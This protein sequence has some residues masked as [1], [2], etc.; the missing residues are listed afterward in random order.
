M[1]LAVV[2]VAMLA[3]SGCL[4][5]VSKTETLEVAAEELEIASKSL[6]LA[7][8]NGSS[9][10]TTT[11]TIPSATWTTSPF[12]STNYKSVTLGAELHGVPKKKAAT[13]AF[14]EITEEGTLELRALSMA[15]GHADMAY[16]RLIDR[17]PRDL[18][19]LGVVGVDDPSAKVTLRIG[20]VKDWWAPLPIEN[21]EVAPETVGGP[22]SVGFDIDGSFISPYGGTYDY[23]MRYGVE[24]SDSRVQAV[25]ASAG[26]VS[27][28][29]KHALSSP[30]VS[31][32]FAFHDSSGG[33]GKWTAERNVDGE[34]KSAEGRF[35][36]FVSPGFV[37]SDARVDHDVTSRFALDAAESEYFT[38]F[39]AYTSPLDLEALD[40]TFNE[41]FRTARAL[42][43]AA[44]DET[45]A[46]VIVDGKPERRDAGPLRLDVPLYSS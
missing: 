2:L 42:P 34:K 46:F 1:R 43:I 12:G 22:I 10:A 9:S 18:T 8:P 23:Q 26:P 32:T 35:A 30:G 17:E 4:V 25:V 6:I 19:L 45:G 7:I 29:A 28:S 27:I 41:R 14:Y 36:P 13:V 24:R 39:L 16:F 21:E 38:W 31:H 33:T 20:V 15:L 3:S 5:A 40:V 44:S 37:V 11:I